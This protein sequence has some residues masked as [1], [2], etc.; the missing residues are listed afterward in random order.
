MADEQKNLQLSLPQVLKELKNLLSGVLGDEFEQLVLYGSRARDEAQDD[1]DVD[2]LIVLGQEFDFFDLQEQVETIV[3]DL[4]KQ[5]EIEISQILITKDRFEHAQ[6][7][8]LR[9][10]RKDCVIV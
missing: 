2:V 8:F 5:C 10:V 3:S 9:N 1:S 7:G 4:S 6:D